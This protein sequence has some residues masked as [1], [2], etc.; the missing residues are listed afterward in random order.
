M[1]R[2]QN[3]PLKK[4]IIKA[5]PFHGKAEWLINYSYFSQF[6]IKVKEILEEIIYTILKL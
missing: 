5:E 3:I 4:R 2:F 1:F 6:K